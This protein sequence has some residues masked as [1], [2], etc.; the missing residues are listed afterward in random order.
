MSIQHS[1]LA[2]R[3]GHTTGLL[4]DIEQTA[5]RHSLSFCQVTG[6]GELARAELS[7]ASDG[8]ARWYT[9]PFQLVNLVGR[10]RRAGDQTIADYVC[11]LARQTDNGIELL[12]GR[13]LRAEAIYAEVTLET[14]ELADAVESGDPLPE[15]PAPKQVAAPSEDAPAAGAQ[16]PLDSRWAA[17][18]EESRRVERQSADLPSRDPVRPKSGDIVDHQQ[19]GRCKVS[20]VTDDHVALRKPEGRIVQLGLSVLEFTVEGVED[21]KRVLTVQVKKAR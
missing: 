6:F 7:C 11:T 1:K 15:R 3:F 17:V 21:G 20:K 9:G 4:G 16:P 2:V 19:F 5:G 10:V 8:E 18:V 12:G 14:L 13:L